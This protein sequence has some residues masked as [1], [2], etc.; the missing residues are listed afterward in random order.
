MWFWQHWGLFTKKTDIEDLDVISKTTQGFLQKNDVEDIDMISETL[1]AFR[2][3]KPNAM[4]KMWF[5]KVQGAFAKK[6]T[7]PSRVLG[8]LFAY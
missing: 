5:R 2:K 8:D 3:K 6:L 4:T 1:R 7:W